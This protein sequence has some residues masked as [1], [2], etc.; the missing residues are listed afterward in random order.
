MTFEF[1]ELLLDAKIDPETVLVLRHCPIEPRLRAFFPYLAA[2]EPDLFNAYQ[3]T[4]TPRVEKAMQKAAYVAS[5]IGHR[6]SLALYVGLY[7][8]KGAERLTFSSHWKNPLLC[9]LKSE[10]GMKGLEDRKKTVLWFDLTKTEFCS[11]WMGKLVVDWPGKEISWFRWATK[12]NAFT[13]RSILEESLLVDRMPTWAQ[14]KLAW[15]QLDSMPTSW[16]ETLSLW[17][18]V[19]YI[20]DAS[21]RKGYVGAAYGTD[22]LLG[23]WKCYWKTGDGG[24]NRLKGRDPNHFFFSILEILP[25]GLD[26]SVVIQTETD[27]KIRLSTR[28]YGLNDN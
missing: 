28:E 6:P 3:Q 19:Y 25:N 10:Y 14:L 1:R 23:R 7:Q 22:N 24:N 5:F 26:P 8:C 27:W 2:H 21:D 16:K 18:G 9:R 15:A 11:H 20:F 4:Q 13:V 12:K 17:R